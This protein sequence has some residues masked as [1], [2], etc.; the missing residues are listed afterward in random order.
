VDQSS[1]KK[2]SSPNIFFKEWPK[3][4]K[5]PE[6][7]HGIVR[8]INLKVLRAPEKLHKII[9]DS[10]QDFIVINN[11]RPAGS[12]YYGVNIKMICVRLTSGV[13]DGMD[14][15]RLSAAKK[16]SIRYMKY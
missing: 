1:S 14:N 5:S 15:F 7:R 13:K 9:P 3:H 6:N 11:G 4:I 8:R 16:Y 10:H 12:G 2:A